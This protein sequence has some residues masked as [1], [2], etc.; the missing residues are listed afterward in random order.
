MFL[1]HPTCLFFFE[2]C[3]HLHIY[4]LL[5]IYSILKSTFAS[6]LLMKMLPALLLWKLNWAFVLTFRLP[7][8]SNH[9][10]PTPLLP[11]KL[12]PQLQHYSF[13][14]TLYMAWSLV[15][16]TFSIFFFKM[17][18]CITIVIGRAMFEVR[19][20]IVQSQK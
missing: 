18:Q 13:Q 16:L 9:W 2:N 4:S 11:I 5:H 12:L 8:S 20:S 6:N 1:F 19:C 7:E 10:I 15:R 17:L 3:S 14:E